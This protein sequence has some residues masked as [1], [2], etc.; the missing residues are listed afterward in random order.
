MDIS[1]NSAC[2]FANKESVWQLTLVAK[3]LRSLRLDLYLP[4]PYNKGLWTDVVA[5]QLQQFVASLGRK[6]H[7]RD[8]K[9]LIASWHRF[10]D[11][12]DW[13]ADILGLLG[14]LRVR[15]HIEVRTRRSLDGKVK[16]ALQSLDLTNKVRDRPKSRKVEC[17]EEVCQLGCPDMDWEW[18]GG[19][20][21]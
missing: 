5:M 18:E 14:Q 20:I 11:L 19:V 4:D 17:S 12:P 6:S 8:L 13:Q 21:I 7:L 2:N 15:G 3:N 16:T 9:I 1:D 10:R